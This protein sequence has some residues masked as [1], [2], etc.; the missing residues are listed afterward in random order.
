VIA[1]VG[2]VLGA[3]QRCAGATRT[4]M[5]V[6]LSTAAVILVPGGWLGAFWLD[7]GLIGA[8]LAFLV[9][10]VIH[11]AIMVWLFRRGA[12]LQVRL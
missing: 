12:W 3:A 9:W 4:V 11:G 8:W 1:A 6:D 10:F 5:I 7:Q 2:L